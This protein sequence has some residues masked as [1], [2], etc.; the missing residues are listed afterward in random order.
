MIV[1][2]Q[3][4]GVY[5]IR[6][7]VTD[8]GYIG[9]TV[10]FHH[11]WLDHRSALRRGSH[12]NRFLQRAWD[13]YGED[14]FEFSEI[15]TVPLNSTLLAEQLI[16]DLALKIVGQ[17]RLYNIAS[18]VVAPW[19]GKRRSEETKKKISVKKLGHEVSQET[20]SRIS[21]SSKGRKIS[22]ET[23][24]KI[25]TATKGRVFS[26]EHRKK[27]SNARIAY[28]NNLKEK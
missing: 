14:T 2:L 22:Q 16:L 7:T 26:E 20:R 24:K 21:R 8:M 1:K 10:N 23:R 3:L 19:L 4:G 9:G 25:S 17:S 28:V 15:I 5:L 11:R 13:K 18:D 27:L 12:I 6:N